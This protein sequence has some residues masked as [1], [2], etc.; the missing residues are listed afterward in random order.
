MAYYAIQTSSGE[1]YHHGI[2]GQKWGHRNGP[3]YPLTASARS[4]SEKKPGRSSSLAKVVKVGRENRKRAAQ[5]YQDYKNELKTAKQNRK[6]RDKA[7]Q[8]TYDK[9]EREI[10]SRYK[11]GQNLS[12]KDARRELA[13]DNKAMDSWAKSKEQYKQDRINAKNSYN[14]KL[15]EGNKKAMDSVSYK[16]IVKSGMALAGSGLLSYGIGKAL[17]N[18]SLPVGAQYAGAFF[19]GAGAGLLMSSVYATAYNAYAKN[20]YKKH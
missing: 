7:I 11:R 8:E 9:T 1:L 3:P 5:D 15:Y 20:Y 17:S 2:L 6:N 19:E 4:A 14:K 13:A 12:D 18:S 10:E 16:D